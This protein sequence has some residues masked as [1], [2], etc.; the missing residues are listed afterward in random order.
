MP[1]LGQCN[2]LQCTL[3]IPW[4]LT[5]YIRVARNA[6]TSSLLTVPLE[7]RT[8]IY[9]ELLGDRLVHLRYRREFDDDVGSITKRKKLGQTAWSHA[10]CEVDCPESVKDQ[11]KSYPDS[12]GDGEEVDWLNPHQSCDVRLNYRNWDDEPFPLSILRSCR[13]IYHEAGQILWST[14]T[15]SFTDGAT[16]Q[17]FMGTRSLIQKRTLKK[18][19]FE[20]NWDTQ[21]EATRWNSALNITIIRSLQGL[22]QLRMCIY[23]S[24]GWRDYEFMK[25]RF[26]TPYGTSYVKGI[27]RMAIL[28]LT[29]VEIAVKSRRSIEGNWSKAERTEYAEG[30]RKLL[31]DPRGAEVYAQ[32]QMKLGEMYQKQ[33][34]VET[35]TKASM[36]TTCLPIPDRPGAGTSDEAPRL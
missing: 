6:V 11:G 30:L 20:M 27:E 21:E 16:F 3:E 32:R 18:L 7:I 4:F 15:F 14:N 10:V 5:H 19:R 9:S 24:L 33:R 17:R 31:L 29:S 12:G 13:Q 23:Y 28:P 22:R 34:K 8:K 35:K 25:Y 26:T 1:R 36:A 2:D